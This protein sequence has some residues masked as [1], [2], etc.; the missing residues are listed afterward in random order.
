MSFSTRV[1]GA[2]SVVAGV[3]GVGL[4]FAAEFL[5]ARSRHLLFASDTVGDIGDGGESSM[6]PVSPMSVADGEIP[7]ILMGIGALLAV[8]AIVFAVRAYNARNRS[9]YV[10][11]GF[12]A[13]ILALGW[14]GKILL[15]GF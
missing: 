8:V 7:G 10:A 9:P 4:V 13:G 1:L 15:F 5:Y 2:L 3:L 14:E 12:I 6:G 11:S